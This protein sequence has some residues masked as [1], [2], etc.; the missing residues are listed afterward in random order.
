MYFEFIFLSLIL[1]QDLFVVVFL[2]IYLT[3]YCMLRFAFFVAILFIVVL[4]HTVK[5]VIEWN[6]CTC[7]IGCETRLIFKYYMFGLYD[8]KVKKHQDIQLQGHFMSTWTLEYFLFSVVVEEVGEAREEV[9]TE[10]LGVAREEVLEV[11]VEEGVAKEVEPTGE[12]QGNNWTISL[13]STCQ[14]QNLIWT[15]S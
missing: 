3:C 2:L 12:C 7:E 14:K 10:D 5:N 9:E 15:K 13:R 11:E 6:S 4:Y 8:I 1:V